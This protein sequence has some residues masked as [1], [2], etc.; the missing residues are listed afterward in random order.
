[1]CLIS[2]VHVFRFS[3]KSNMQILSQRTEHEVPWVRKLAT[4]GAGAS[5]HQA[6]ATHFV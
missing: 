5:M 4:C 2:C 3:H 6:R 1:M